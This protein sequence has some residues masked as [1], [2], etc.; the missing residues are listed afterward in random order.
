MNSRQK[1]ARGEIEWRDQIRAAGWEAKRGQQFAGGSDSPDVISD[2]PIHWEVKR[3]QKLNLSDAMAQAVR[4]SAGK[5]APV[6]A[7]RKNGEQW[8]V[9]LRAEDFFRI[10]RDGVEGL[11]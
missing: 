11:K 6:V 7:H 10:L 3:V 1:G 4:D 2:L 9:T 8:L 5:L